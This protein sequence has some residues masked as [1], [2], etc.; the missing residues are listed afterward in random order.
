MDNEYGKIFRAPKVRQAKIRQLYQNDALG[1]VDQILTDQTEFYQLLTYTGDI[2]LN[3]QLKA[4][5]NFYN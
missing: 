5:E 1:A 2:D 4:W 3:V